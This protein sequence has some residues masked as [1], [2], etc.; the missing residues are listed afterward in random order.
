MVWRR[1]CT[2]FRSVECGHVKR[3]WGREV[4]YPTACV[5]HLAR[6][7][8]QCGEAEHACIHPAAVMMQIWRHEGNGRPDS[9]LHRHG[10]STTLNHNYPSLRHHQSADSQFSECI[11]NISNNASIRRKCF[12]SDTTNKQTTADLYIKGS[13]RH[14]K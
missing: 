1:Y 12:N 14:S 10:A 3:V 5:D 8:L 7:A 9:H 4:L 6:P 13:Q 2:L 11:Y